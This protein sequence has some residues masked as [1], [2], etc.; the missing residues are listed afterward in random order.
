MINN[1]VLDSNAFFKS[2]R[3]VELVKETTPYTTSLVMNELKDQKTKQILESFP[4]KI[5]VREPSKEAI[6]FVKNFSVLTGDSA[7]LSDTDIG[8]IALS[9]DLIEKIGMKDKLNREPKPFELPKT[10]P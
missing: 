4:F 7:S 1:I 3:L 10:N 8:V 2:N 9:Y 5:E 6:K